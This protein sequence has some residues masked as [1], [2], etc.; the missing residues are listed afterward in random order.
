MCSF[1]H[2]GGTCPKCGYKIPDF[3][4]LIEAEEAE[5]VNLKKPEPATM[6]DKKRFYGMLEYLRRSKGYKNGWM[7]HKYKSK[8]QVWPR[9]MD[10]VGPIPPDAKFNNWIIYQNIKYWKGK[11]KAA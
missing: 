1:Q 4:K 7:A 6:E 11:K 3:G 2:T 9:G 5:L 10:D 8:F